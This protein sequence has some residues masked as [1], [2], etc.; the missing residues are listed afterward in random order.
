MNSQ[1]LQRAHGPIDEFCFILNRNVLLSQ[2]QD[3][4]VLIHLTGILLFFSAHYKIHKN[5][6]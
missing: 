6:N 3:N 1:E 2:F 5:A 4:E